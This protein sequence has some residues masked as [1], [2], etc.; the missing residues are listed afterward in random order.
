MAVVTPRGATADHWHVYLARSRSDISI[1]EAAMG[2][3][4]GVK[5]HVSSPG[6]DHG[7]YFAYP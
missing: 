1:S 3:A 4:G 5:C 7:R 2:T 6:A